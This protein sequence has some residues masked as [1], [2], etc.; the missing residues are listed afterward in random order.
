MRTYN[1]RPFFREKNARCSLKETPDAIKKIARSS[2]G[3]T[4][5]SLVAQTIIC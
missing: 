2:T 1:T 3:K 5:D 4:G